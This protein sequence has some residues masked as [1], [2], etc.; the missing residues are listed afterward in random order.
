MF[1]SYS[2]HHDV[3]SKKAGYLGPFVLGPTASESLTSKLAFYGTS[4]LLSLQDGRASDGIT[5][6]ANLYATV[7][8]FTLLLQRTPW[9]LK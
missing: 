9:H 3:S 5:T 6:S 1:S 7:R 8:P 4:L 2:L